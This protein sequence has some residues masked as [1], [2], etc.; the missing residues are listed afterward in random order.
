[1]KIEDFSEEEVRLKIDEL[2]DKYDTICL[3]FNAEIPDELKLTAA[4]LQYSTYLGA[5][6]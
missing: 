3:A 1:M 6:R 2:R 5:K 4:A